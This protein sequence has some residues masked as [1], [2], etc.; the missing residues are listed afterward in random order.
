L[1]TTSRALALELASD[2]H[3]AHQHAAECHSILLTPHQWSHTG[4]PA[5]TAEPARRRQLLPQH[6]CPFQP[7]PGSCLLWMQGWCRDLRAWHGGEAQANFTPIFLVIL[8]LAI[9]KVE[10]QSLLEMP[11]AAPCYELVN[12]F[13]EKQYWRQ[14]G[15][16]SQ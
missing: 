16:G 10:F 11:S 5:P 8:E 9:P 3:P 4:F 15:E 2:C 13:L 7:L 12:T 1:I 14:I 6:F